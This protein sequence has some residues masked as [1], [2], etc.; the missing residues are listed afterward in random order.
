M[1]RKSRRIYVTA[2]TSRLRAL[3]VY[4]IKNQMKQNALN[5]VSRRENNFRLFKTLKIK[6]ETEIYTI[7][8]CILQFSVE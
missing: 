3:S 7:R 4:L 1:K 6:Q 8:N 2:V 5:A